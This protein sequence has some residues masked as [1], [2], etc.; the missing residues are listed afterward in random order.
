MHQGAK[1]LLRRL[2]VKQRLLLQYTTDIQLAHLT[3]TQ[4]LAQALLF[5]YAGLQ[6]GH[7]ALRLGQI[8]VAGLPGAHRPRDQSRQFIL[9]PGDA[10]RI[11][12]AKPAVTQQF[13]LKGFDIGLTQAEIRRFLQRQ[14]AE[15]QALL[16]GHQLIDVALQKISRALGVGHRTGEQGG[17]HHQQPGKHFHCEL[18]V[19]NGRTL[20]QTITGTANRV[21]TRWFLVTE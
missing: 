9:L 5:A 19:C 6:I 2:T 4:R 15:L 11:H 20:D 10:L 13:H 8:G 12:H 1:Y 3:V 21:V 18:L 16:D 14:K 7:Q 17:H